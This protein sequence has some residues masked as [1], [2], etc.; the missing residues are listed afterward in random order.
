MGK[1]QLDEINDD[2]ISGKGRGKKLNH[3][4]MNWQRAAGS[5][6]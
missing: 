2:A 6:L 1:A 3:L 4:R 5:A